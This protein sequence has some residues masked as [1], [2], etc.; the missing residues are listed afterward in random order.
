VVNIA[1]PSLQSQLHA[2]EVTLELV[3]G[4]YTFS[5]ASILVTGG[6]L[7][8]V[9]SYR[10]LFLIGMSLFTATS[11]LCGV[12]QT[13][14]QLV[15]ARVVQGLAA[16]LMVPQVVAL[17]TVTFPPAERPRALSWFG[18]TV[19]LASVSGQI[20]GGLLLTADLFGLGWRVIFLVNLPIGLVTVALGRRLLPRA[21][22]AR[23][24][25]QDVVGTVGVSVS[26]ALAILPLIVGHAEG[27]PTWGWIMLGLSVPA[28]V[29]TV[30]YERALPG[31][32]GEPLLDLTLFQ[33]RSFTVG[34]LTMIGIMSFYSGFI[35]GLT[36]FLQAGLHLDPLQ[37]GLTFGPMG[38]GFA[39]SALIARPLTMKYG[40][41]VISAGQGLL[42][43]GLVGLLIAL[44]LDGVSAGAGL[45]IAPM[46]LVGL[47]TGL[48]VPS[49]T[50]VV[51]SQVRPQ[52]AG[53]ASGLLTTAQQFA[54]TIGVAVFG[55]IFFDTLGT[56]PDRAEYVSSL[57]WVAGAGLGLSVVSLALCRLLPRGA[58]RPPTSRP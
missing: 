29:V 58:V 8:D 45:L 19:G 15:A 9:F 55:V 41:R 21:R 36:I 10:R 34:L 39:A 54:N 26:L 3:I 33:A 52:Q 1:T 49:L 13:G 18:V 14:H 16:A 35:F 23:R 44:R 30:L 46:A 48:T 24:P 42:V 28:I 17:I 50:G 51:I 11:L 43:L 31:R 20:L 7:G 57:E 53:V 37:A 56:A 25:R 38:L 27:W 47:G 4:G 40:S 22:A 12:S 32:G 5:Y 6:R 2:G